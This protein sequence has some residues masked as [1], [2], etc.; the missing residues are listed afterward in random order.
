MIDS[1]GVKRGKNGTMVGGTTVPFSVN[2]VLREL[3]KNFE[4]DAYKTR[5]VWYHTILVAELFLILIV[6]L[7][8]LAK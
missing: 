3:R 5:W 8:L 1:K 6:L 2:K 7:L 4:Q